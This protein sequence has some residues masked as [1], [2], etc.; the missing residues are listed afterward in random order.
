M[1]KSFVAALVAVAMPL[2]LSHAQQQQP[3]RGSR[4]PLAR[5]SLGIAVEDVPQEEGT[6]RGVVIRRIW[7][8]SAAAKAGLK[9]G[10][11]IT[12]ISNRQINDYEDLISNLAGH[13]PGDQLTFSIHR[14]GKTEQVKVTLGKPIAASQRTTPMEGLRTCAFL[15][16]VAAPVAAL[17][18]ASRNRFGLKNEQGLVVMDVVPNSPA[19]QAGL[20]LGDLIRSVDGEEVGQPQALRRHVLDAG[21]GKEIKLTIMRGEQTKTVTAKLAEGPCDIMLGSPSTGQY[22]PEPAANTIRQLERRLNDLE[23]RV[24]ELESKHPHDKGQ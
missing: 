23:R 4:N 5:V 10:D 20:R 24:K 14:D 13:K 22:Y 19:A 1:L 8:D 18:E 2:G 16:V 21:P 15:G 6:D 7:P 9:V 3:E 17:P 11:V 12:R